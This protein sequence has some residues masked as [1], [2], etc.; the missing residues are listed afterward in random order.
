MSMTQD[1]ERVIFLDHE[2]AIRS[3]IAE[4]FLQRLGG[5]GYEVCSGGIEPRPVHPLTA[6]VMGEV[7]YDI[8]LQESKSAQRYFGRGSAFQVAILVSMPDERDCPRLFP[9]ALRV[10]R[11]PNRDPLT[12]DQDPA[13]LLARFRATR[14]NLKLQT[15]VWV[16][17]QKDAKT[18]VF[19]VRR[20]RAVPH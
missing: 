1:R 2:N 8:H 13:L 19:S 11:W 17:A 9:G 14:D 15:E 5:D 3:Q 12:G 18:G 16:K 6:V 7:G 4:A 10:E 20:A